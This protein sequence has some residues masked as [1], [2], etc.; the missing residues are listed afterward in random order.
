MTHRQSR[1]P[2]H[3]SRAQQRR[4]HRRRR[5]TA[6]ALLL[7]ALL[8]LG[9]GLAFAGGSPPGASGA[10]PAAEVQ[11]QTDG[12]L[13]A[14]DV[15]LIGAS[16][17]EAAG[18]TWGVGELGEINSGN[19]AIMQYTS[20]GGWR[21][22]PDATDSTGQSLTDFVPLE[23]T[24]MGAITPAGAG[25]LVGTAADPKRQVLLL[26]NPGGAFT[27]AVLPNTGAGALMHSGENVFEEGRTPLVVPLDEGSR[28]GAFLVPVTRNTGGE[29]HVLHYDGERWS[30]EPIE[31][32]A[33]TALEGGGFHVLAIAA[34]SPS[35][36]W[37]LAQLSRQ[38][39]NVA[40]F[41]RHEERWEEVSPSSLTVAGEPFAIPGDGSGSIPHSTGQILTVT[42]TG[43]WVDGE[44]SDVDSRVTMYLKPSAEGEAASSVEELHAWCDPGE[45]FAGCEELP[46]ALPVGAS[47]SFAWSGSSGESPY[48]ERVITGLGEGVTL[49]LEGTSFK[50]VLALGGS[51]APDDVGG[52]FGAAFSSAREGW[53]GNDEMP[54]HLTLN[55][56]PDRLQYWPVPF[57]Y[58]LAAIAPQP[59]AP[60]GALSSE[61]LAVGEH[62]EIARYVPGEGWEPET[63]FGPGER[64]EAPPLR[65][66]AWPTPTRAYAVG[67]ISTTAPATPQMWLWRGETG[68]WEPD[69]ATPLNFRGNLLGI[70]FDPGNPSV[71]YAVGQQGVLLRYGK[72]WTQEPESAIPAEAQGASFTSVAFAGS[73]AL[74]AFRKNHPQQSGEPQHYTGGLLVNDGSGWQ[75]DTAAS[76]ALGGAIP[77]SVAGLP[78]GGAA[79]AGTLGG[80]PGTA[81]VIE[82]QSAQGPWQATAPYP[83]QAPGSLA[84]F[85]EGGALRA[86][87]AGGLPNTEL[88]E[89]QRTLP[90][91]L[92]PE[93]VDPYPLTGGYV[94]RQTAEGWSDE[95][96]ARNPVQDPLGE[97]QEYD[98]VYQP[99]PSAAM[100]ISEDGSAGWAV[101]GF[102]D[103]GHTEFDTADVARYPA[104]STSPPGAQVAAVQ[105]N[106][107]QAALDGS[108]ATFAIGGGAQCV[109][110]CVNRSRAGLGP[111]IWLATAL[112]QA[113]RVGNARGFIY[114]GPR[115]TTGVGHGGF[116]VEYGR[117]FARYAELLNSAG[118][119]LPVFPVA[120]ESDSGPGT[121]CEFQQAFSGFSQP[122]G[123]GETDAG[124]TP[125]VTDEVQDFRSSGDCSTYYAWS[126]TSPSGGA[127]P[128]RV[129][130]IDTTAEGQEWAAERAWLGNELAAAAAAREPAIVAGNADLN[131]EI[132][133]HRIEAEEA[134]QTI[135]GGHAS[136]YFYD[137]P[138]ENVEASLDDSAT[139]AFGSGTLGYGSAVSAKLTDYL[140]A[141]GFLLVHVDV[142]ARRSDNLA[143]VS[144]RLIPNVGELALEAEEGT[145]LR[146]SQAASFSGLARRPRAGGRSQR[147][148][149]VN[150]ASLYIPIPENCV[151]ARCAHRI[152][153]EYTISSSEPEIGKFVTRNTAVSEPNAVLLGGPKE[154]PLPLGSNEQN[155]ESGLFCAFNPG[156][157]TVTISAGGLSS[158]LTV[159]VQA[160]S[161]RRPCG[162]VPDHKVSASTSTGVPAPPPVQPA[163]NVNTGAS[164]TSPPVPLPAPPP[165]PAPAPA[166]PRPPA[167][168][169]LQ[170]ALAVPLL[171]F[172]P[173]PVP[174]PARPSPPSGTSAVT[175]PVEI[176]EHE[177]ESEEAPESVSNQA[178]AYRSSE[179]EPDPAYILAIIAL[180]A[181]AG[182]SARRRGRRGPREVRLAEARLSDRRRRRSRRH[183]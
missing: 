129:I 64:H 164:P 136:A 51:A 52:E 113:R 87:G 121:E 22:G 137:A 69:P 95:E 123:S 111:D 6:A 167:P 133:E 59:D 178:V 163:A 138:E 160:G 10:T 78:D 86:V 56:A 41:H 60:P 118:E 183:W 50:R 157:T 13:P 37:L 161:V 106:P 92:P 74:V 2:G 140:G 119:Q 108:E 84:L 79:V 107:T 73:E 31:V 148:R 142:A 7:A 30:E 101:G 48:G 18:E 66:V 40:L 131:A 55:P 177:E 116:P 156:Q 135:I 14:R 26:R 46:T 61:A 96:R 25:E 100:L 71:G 29:E 34:S 152:A 175:S 162:T 145:L 17:E 165:A 72:T 90:P 89:Q 27:E 35:N 9:L 115:V 114:T 176:A 16:P 91:S 4:I 65:A 128:V 169:T 122:L 53:L 88:D 182:A 12:S 38:S 99:D 171:P 77:W 179:H 11:V 15:T 57:R 67:V 120:S 85:R 5:L 149:D 39:R 159:T 42:P 158:S 70:A 44:R 1:S 49:R 80:L 97:Y 62:G 170:P 125:F 23:T 144:A 81:T 141:N 112:R 151:G 24:L 181:L 76:A 134:A 3:R 154:E 63:P 102:A 132:E 168:F 94:V 155:L 146:R 45:G 8:T 166:A 68:R 139:P 109:A 47:R 36:A 147:G 180:A 103:A 110:A 19:F 124:V 20:Q 28:A 58:A 43:I 105:P 33:A 54:V 32:P 98:M 153:P 174:T 126:S 83:G 75:I 127:G 21:V 82:R 150:E 143:P 104:E 130:V 172:V 117:E 173:P 93:L